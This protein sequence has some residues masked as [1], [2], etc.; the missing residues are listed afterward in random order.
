LNVAPGTKLEM[1][2]H[3]FKNVKCGN[4]LGKKKWGQ[5]GIMK[6]QLMEPLLPEGIYPHLCPDA[7]QGVRPMEEAF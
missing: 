7:Y 3:V 1:G 2:P 6:N 5:E 4:L